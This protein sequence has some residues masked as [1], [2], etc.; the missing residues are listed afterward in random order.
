MLMI[1]IIAIVVIGH[2]SWLSG[3]CVLPCPARTPLSKMLAMSSEQFGVLEHS[4]Q[5]CTQHITAWW[6]SKKLRQVSRHRY[7]WRAK[8]KKMIAHVGWAAIM[9]DHQ[10]LA[11]SVASQKCRQRSLSPATRPANQSCLSRHFGLETAMWLWQTPTSLKLGWTGVA[12]CSGLKKLM[13]WFC[14]QSHQIGPCWFA[15]V[16]LMACRT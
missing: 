16:R 9:L 8:A 11:T 1:V 10:G 6:S 14:L 5:N 3:G 2:D 15:K 12:Q 4:H 7:Y 13:C